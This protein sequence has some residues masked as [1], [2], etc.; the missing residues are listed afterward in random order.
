MA[1]NEKESLGHMKNGGF[2]DKKH[3]SEAKEF[4]KKYNSL[5][6][7]KSKSISKSLDRAKGESMVGKL[8]RLVKEPKVDHW[9]NFKKQHKIK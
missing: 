6:P 4:I 8:K 1:I 2:G 3:I 7:H 9:K 5:P